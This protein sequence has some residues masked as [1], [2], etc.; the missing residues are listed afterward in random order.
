MDPSF[1]KTPPAERERIGLFDL[2]SPARQAD[3]CLSC[4]IG[5]ANEGKV[6]THDMYA[7][8]HPPL[9][10]IEVATFSDLIPRHWWLLAEK[11]I[12]EGPQGRRATRTGEQERTRL[13][14]V[15]AAVAP[16]DLDEAPGRRDPRPTGTAA[17]PGLDWPDYA[18]F[19]CWSCHH[20]LK[21][22]SWRQARGF[23]G[24]PGR[25]P[26]SEW[27]LAMVE[28]GIDRLE[29]NDRFRWTSSGGEL[30]SPPEGRPRRGPTPAPSDG[31]SP[32]H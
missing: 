5:N 20:D 13:A 6:V 11:K 26:I 24:S 31:K 8:G 27:P 7:A 4:H 30:M 19:D 23:T 9:P 3:Q 22:E 16:Q 21:R 32:W 28:L 18:R 17:V 10:S 25:P 1:R 29:L 15:G 12:R 2:R 14:L